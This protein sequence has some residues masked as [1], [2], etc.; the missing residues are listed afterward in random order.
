MKKS[1]LIA[2]IACLGLLLPFSSAGL[3]KELA[4]YVV[5]FTYDLS[6]LRAEVGIPE[7]R[8]AEI[9]LDKINAAGG[10]N[11]RQL[12]AVFYDH[13]GKEAQSVKNTKRLIEVDKAVAV[14]GYE[15]VSITFASIATATEAKTFLFS[16]GPAIVSGAPAKKWLFG[17]VPDQKI[18]SIPILIKNLLARGC[19]KIAYIYT[20]TTYGSL[21]LKAVD[22]SCKKLGITPTIIEKYAPD[23][24]DF[25]PQ[26]SH[27]K[28]SGADGLLITGNVPDTVKVIK[29]ARELGIQ[30]PIVCDYAIVGPEFI[31]LGKNIVEGVVSTSL[32]ALVAPDLPKTDPQK[33]VCM[34]LYNAYTKEHKMIS[35][36]AGHGWD[37]VYLLAKALE[38]VDSNLDPTKDADL[39][40]I[41]EQLRDS[42]ENIKGFVGQNGIFNYSPTDHVGLSEGC[43]VPVVVKNGK[44]VLYTR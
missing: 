20:D 36:Y 26:L 32:K 3:A 21:G 15:G 4:P 28:A 27:I 8:G 44:W 19:R 16:G 24:I 39:T 13:A 18:A 43:Y 10:V 33:E 30:Y 14:L 11:G 31:E 2:I 6:G 23:T 35:L 29:A 25:S 37:Q 9:A 42:L 22:A 17:V 34:Q 12:Q 1:L 40:K 38:K 7:K 41:R 5:G